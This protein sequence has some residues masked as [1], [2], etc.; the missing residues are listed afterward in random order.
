MHPVGIASPPPQ[1][2]E[3][4]L[5]CLK[6]HG[7]DS[8][9]CRDLAKAYL[10]CRMER[11]A[12]APPVAAAV[13]PPACSIL[14]CPPLLPGRP[15]PANG[16][17]PPLACPVPRSNLMAPQDLKELGFKEGAGPSPAPAP[18]QDSGKPKRR[19]ETEGYLAGMKRFEDNRD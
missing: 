13:E 18:K 17:G 9:A 10:Q 7:N 5:A 14:P 4:Y 2:K 1:I 11:C 16:N 8:E 3:Q 15:S 12:A 19:I 6:E